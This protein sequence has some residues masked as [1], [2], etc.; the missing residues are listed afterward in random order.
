MYF[1][2][3][4]TIIVYLETNE[5]KSVTTERIMGQKISIVVMVMI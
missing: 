3:S 5:H 1:W 4:M 2:T